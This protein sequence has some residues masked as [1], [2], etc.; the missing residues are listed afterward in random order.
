MIVK[1]CGMKYPDNIDAVGNLFPDFMGF[2]FYPLSVR[3][4]LSTPPSNIKVP[5]T[6][7]RI[8][9]FVNEDSQIIEQH[10]V[11]YRLSGV[12]LHGNELP[13]TCSYFKKKGL[14]V[15]KAFGISEDFNFKSLIDYVDV[16]DMFV[17]DTKVKTHGGSGQKFDWS[18]L[19]NYTYS[20]P[21]LLSGGISENDASE[22]KKINHPALAG[23][24]LNSCFEIKPGLK[25]VS[26]LTHFIGELYKENDN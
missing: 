21:F 8:G 9:V 3:Y 14:T 22:V 11:D 10:I 1:V 2:I 5:N 24:D 25:D 16:V 19:D 20:V 13:S 7:G 12:Q 18:H 6:I 15:F 4:V 26:K 17:F 23:V